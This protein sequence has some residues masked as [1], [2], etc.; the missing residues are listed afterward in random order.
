MA[1]VLANLHAID[2]DAVGLGDLGR[3]ENYLA[4]QIRRWRTQWEGAKTR[5]LPAMEEVADAAGGR[6]AGPSAGPASSTATTGWAT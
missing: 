3:K 6:H 1:E 5:E 4:R 2:P